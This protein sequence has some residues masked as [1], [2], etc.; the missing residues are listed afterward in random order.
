MPLWAWI[1]LVLGIVFLVVFVI[2]VANY[3][4]DGSF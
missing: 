2:T 3:P 4:E 1:A